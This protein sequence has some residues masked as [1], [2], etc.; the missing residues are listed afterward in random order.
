MYSIL[1]LLYS[2]PACIAMISQSSWRSA[3][4]AACVSSCLSCLVLF[5]AASFGQIGNRSG[6]VKRVTRSRKSAEKQWRR[7]AELRHPFALGRGYRGLNG[8]N[9]AGQ[10]NHQRYPTVGLESEHGAIYSA[11]LQIGTFS[12]IARATARPSAGELL[13]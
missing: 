3:S 8:A 11:V 2:P 10:L 7:S 12:S 13:A 5:S 9:L 4:F 1:S 6:R